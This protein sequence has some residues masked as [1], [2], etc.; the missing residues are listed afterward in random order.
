MTF[1]LGG[2]PELSMNTSVSAKNTGCDRRWRAPP[3]ET[4]QVVQPKGAK[5]GQDEVS[6]VINSFIVF[7]RIIVEVS[8][9]F[10]GRLVV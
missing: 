4:I 3:D 1:I 9:F 2:D 6:H 5:K 8:V 7:F 10:S